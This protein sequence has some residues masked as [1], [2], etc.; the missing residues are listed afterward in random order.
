MLRSQE[1]RNLGPRTGRAVLCLVLAATLAGCVTVAP[2]ASVGMTVAPP[3]G[4]PAAASDP[5]SASVASPIATIAP[6]TPPSPSDPA[7]SPSPDPSATAAPSADPSPSPD[8]TVVPDQTPV[9]SPTPAGVRVTL[10]GPGYAVTIPKDWQSVAADGLSLKALRRSNPNLASF[11]INANKSGGQI[12]FYA[13]GTNQ[14]GEVTDGFITAHTAVTGVSRSALKSFAI[15]QLRLLAHRSG[16][17]QATTFDV[18]SGFCVRATTRITLSTAPQKLYVEWYFVDTGSMVYVLAFVAV[19]RN[20]SV[21]AAIVSS[22]EIL[23]QGSGN[24]GK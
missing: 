7:A 3:T 9:A 23:S 15:R 22:L 19:A 16:P 8:P 20:E 18:L 4:T 11:V 10:D 14:D 5:P 6:T 12:D 1:S 13:V 21:H 17:V 2:A 24:K